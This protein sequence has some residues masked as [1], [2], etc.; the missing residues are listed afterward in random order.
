MRFFS[1]AC[2]L[3]LSVATGRRV[4]A[5][6][7]LGPVVAGFMWAGAARAGTTGWKVQ[8]SPNPGGSSNL[9]GVAATSRTNAW[10]VG[11]HI[12]HWNGKAWKAQKSPGEHAVAATSSTNAWAT[13]GEVI[14]HWNGKAWN[15]QP[16]PNIGFLFGVAATSST[17]AWA[18]GGG[19]ILHWNGNG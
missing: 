18:V 15:V 8:P 10:A 7:A 11:N 19:A 3:D 1:G 5:A 17:N 4:P 13:S 2:G 16:S 14:E 6:L 12:E 9:L